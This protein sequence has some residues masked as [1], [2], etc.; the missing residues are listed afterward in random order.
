MNLGP[1]ADPFPAKVFNRARAAC[2]GRVAYQTAYMKANYPALYMAAVLVAHTAITEDIALYIQECRRMGIAVLPPD[3][4]E[5]D[6]DFT[7]VKTAESKEA[8]RFGLATIKNF[9][10]GVARAIVETRKS[11]GPFRSVGELVERLPQEQLNRRALESLA[12]AGGLDSLAERASVIAS[13]DA[14]LDWKRSRARLAAD[15]VSLFG[16]SAAAEATLAKV[17]PAPPESRLAWERE[18]L[19]LYVS[20]HP[21]DPWRAELGKREKNARWVKASGRDGQAAVIAGVIEEVKDIRTKESGEVMSFVTLRDLTDSVEV[22]FFPKARKEN[23]AL[24]LPDKV[25]AVKGTISFRNGERSILAEKVKAL[26]VGA[27]SLRD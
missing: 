12:K 17:P 21:L 20:G 14:L 15:Q 19:G 22:V 25:V 3:V 23:E 8:I 24:L 9:G 18:L 10:E 5:S 4:N 1:P 27:A 6:A 7:V 2:Y 13:L 11:G 16:D 26:S